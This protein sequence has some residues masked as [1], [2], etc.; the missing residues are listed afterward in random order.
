MEC[1]FLIVCTGISH[2]PPFIN[3]SPVLHMKNVPFMVTL[4]RVTAETT[5]QVP[6]VAHVVATVANMCCGMVQRQV[7]E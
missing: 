6:R 1:I 7:Y 4:A 2:G 5:K 3:H